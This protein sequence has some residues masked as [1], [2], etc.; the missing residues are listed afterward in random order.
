MKP[1]DWPTQSYSQLS[2]REW[3]AIY[4]VSALSLVATCWLAL[5]VADYLIGGGI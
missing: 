4:V 2:E 3:I 5:I 1:S